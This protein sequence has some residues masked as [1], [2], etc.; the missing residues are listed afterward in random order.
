MERYAL[1]FSLIMLINLGAV[2]SFILVVIQFEQ[3]MKELE[4]NE[5]SKRN[6]KQ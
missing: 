5:N 6:K 2:I 1:I 4:E 3:T